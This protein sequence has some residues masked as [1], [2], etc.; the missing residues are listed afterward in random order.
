LC[1]FVVSPS[2][3]GGSVTVVARGVAT[4]SSLLY[5]RASA[6]SSFD[7]SQ[8]LLMPASY[9]AGMEVRYDWT[10]MH[11]SAALSFDYVASHAVEPIR[12]Y[13]ATVI[14]VENGFTAVPV[15][16]TGI[17][18]LPFSSHQLQ[19]YM[20]GG[21]GMYTGTRTYRIGA[22]D[23][24]AL[25]MPPGFGIHVLAGVRT[26]FWNRIECSFDIKFRDLQFEAENKFTA[27]TTVVNGAIFTLPQ[28][29]LHSRM[30][31]DGAIFQLGVGVIVW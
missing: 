10:E 24:E 7:R 6:V 26:T 17:V 9:G 19:V 23:A 12:A 4:T 21:V 27:T 31:T 14:P 15:E 25:S 8:S 2:I 22:A 20:G 28:G 29:T 18:L 11:L 3:A 5:P 30:Q 1:A 13:P 16:L